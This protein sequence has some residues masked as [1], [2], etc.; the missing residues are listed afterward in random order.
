[1]TDADRL[2]I[3]ATDLEAEN[4]ALRAQLAALAAENASLRER[5]RAAEAERD[6]LL[7]LILEPWTRGDGQKMWRINLGW[8]DTVPDR[9]HGLA[10]VREQIEGLK[11][12]RDEEAKCPT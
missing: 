5:G 9:E 11:R 8:W 4:K 12:R 7:S 6:D 1:L 10:M 3:M 2:E